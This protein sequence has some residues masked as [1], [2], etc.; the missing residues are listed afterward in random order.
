MTSDQ[1]LKEMGLRRDDEYIYDVELGKDLDEALFKGDVEYIKRY[2]NQGGDVNK[3]E[4]LS[5]SGRT[6][7]T[8]AAIYCHTAIVKLL[9]R[10]G[11]EVNPPLPGR[12]NLLEFV[13]PH[14]DEFNTYIVDILAEAGSTYDINL[15]CTFM[16]EWMKGSRDTPEDDKREMDYRISYTENAVDM[17]KRV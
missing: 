3:R 9:V 12:V 13:V 10:N 17:R 2:I 7:L 14:M 11:A 6:I 5:C 16:A 1:V 8:L 4:S 15:S